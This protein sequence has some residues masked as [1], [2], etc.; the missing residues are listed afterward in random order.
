MFFKGG[1]GYISKVLNWEDMKLLVRLM[2][3]LCYY[4]ST[5][6]WQHFASYYKITISEYLH[7][8]FKVVFVWEFCLNVAM[9][10]I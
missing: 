1:W 5:K 10:K 3:C 8:K 4:V 7:V 2:E 9:R 6:V